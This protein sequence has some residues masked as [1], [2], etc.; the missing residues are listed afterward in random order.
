M[1]PIQA[2]LLHLAEQRIASD[3]KDAAD[4]PSLV[5]VIRME[6]DAGSVRGIT[7]TQRAPAAL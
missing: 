3:A 2:N 6:P 1:N 5:A 4:H 7:I